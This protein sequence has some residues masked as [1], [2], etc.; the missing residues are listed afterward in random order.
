MLHYWTSIRRLP[1]RFS[2]FP[3]GTVQKRNIRVKPRIKV[4][5]F[6]P[7][8]SFT[9]KENSNDGK[10]HIAPK[11]ST[12]HSE[13]PG[14][15]LASYIVFLGAIC[16]GSVFFHSIMKSEF[17]TFESSLNLKID[18]VERKLN[19]LEGRM[20]RL[21]VQVKENKEQLSAKLVGRMERLET[22]LVGKIERLESN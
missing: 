14:S 20:E 5:V 10:S 18:Q 21:V 9:S 19:S 22:N 13:P 8:G 6:C 2:S 16:S 12:Q 3:F 11:R 4:F 7:S 1:P 17:R 15:N